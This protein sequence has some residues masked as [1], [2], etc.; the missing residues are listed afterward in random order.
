ML[1]TMENLFARNAMGQLYLL[2][3]S[4]RLKSC[5]VACVMQLA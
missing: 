5:E 2:I 3:G 4:G 1:D